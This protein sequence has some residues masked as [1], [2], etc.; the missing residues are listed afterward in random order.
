ML[1]T[2]PWAALALAAGLATAHAAPPLQ[3]ALTHGVFKADAE[4]TPETAI[5]PLEPAQKLDALKDATFRITGRDAA[6][7]LSYPVYAEPGS[8]TAAKLEGLGDG[9]FLASLDLTGAGVSDLIYTSKDLPGWKV[10]TNGTRL[11]QPEQAFIAGLF[12]KG[13]RVQDAIPADNRAFTVDNNLLAAVGDF[14]GNGTEQLAY[15]YPGQNQ[16]WVVGAHGVMTMKADLTGFEPAAAGDR[17]HWL[18]AYHANRKGQ[19]TRLAYY[20]TGADHLVRLTPKGME[21]VQ[22]KVPL[23]GHWTR[24][25]QA[26]LDWPQ[27][28]RAQGEK[29]PAAK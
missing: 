5:H 18:F 4:A 14:M 9:A 27:P 20:R 7:G 29:E 22:D 23:K 8:R 28:A 12:V 10:L 21:F 13:A 15:T 19:R 26:E 17:N 3:H 1:R 25:N 11:P 16:I 24:L 2:L 6:D